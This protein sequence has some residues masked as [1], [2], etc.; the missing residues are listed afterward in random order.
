MID[1]IPIWN[2]RNGK[3]KESWI[4]LFVIL[5]NLE[6]IRAYEVTLERF[7][8]VITYELYNVFIPFVYVYISKLKMWIQFLVPK[9]EDGNNFGVSIQVRISVHSLSLPWPVV[10]FLSTDIQ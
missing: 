6:L 8:C 7:N 9:I 5:C 10:S 2:T 4:L 3:V 1:C